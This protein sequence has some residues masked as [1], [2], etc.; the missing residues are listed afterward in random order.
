[1]KATLSGEKDDK[2]KGE[3]E[4]LLDTEEEKAE[5]ALELQKYEQLLNKE[6]II[7]GMVVKTHHFETKNGKQ[8]GELTIE[9]YSDSITLDLWNKDYLDQRPFFVNKLFVIVKLKLFKPHYSPNQVRMNI[10][11]IQLLNEVFEK[12][13]KDMAINL[14]V[15]NISKQKINTLYNT[16]LKYPGNQKLTI[17]LINT[18]DASLSIPSISKSLAIKPSPEMIKELEK[19]RVRFKLK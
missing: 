15:K 19:M 14:F 6:M 2:P 13:P 1:M 4:E 9:D 17:N 5:R 18:D 10:L 8:K 16:L 11:D 12:N 3:G 7:G